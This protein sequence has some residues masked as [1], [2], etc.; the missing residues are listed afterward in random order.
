[1]SERGMITD[2]LEKLVAECLK[3]HR[4]D[5]IHEVASPTL[6]N[7][8]LDFYLPAYGLYIECKRFHTDRLKY[9]IEGLTNVLV[10]QGMEGVVGFTKL[11]DNLA[12]VGDG[13]MHPMMSAY[14]PPNT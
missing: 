14:V 13:Y 8:S 6:N 10:I 4:I 2:P 3:R 12:T 9:Q 5:Y 7:K 11:L 1:M